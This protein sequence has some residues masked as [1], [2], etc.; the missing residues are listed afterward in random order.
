MLIRRET[1]ADRRAI[2]AVHNAAFATE[3]GSI[4]YEATLVDNLRAAGDVIAALSLVT[5]IDGQVVG[6]VLGSR[7][8]IDEH[9]SLGLGPLGVVPS[10]QKRG[11]GSALM[12]A[13]LA[14]ADALDSPEAVLLGDPGYYQRFGFQPAQPLGVIPPDQDWAQHF[15]IRT[16]TRWNDE[17][18]GTFR[19]APAFGID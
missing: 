3:D 16:L 2:H 18:K 4:S 1:P 9:L 15:Q 10:H 8:H 5:E 17:T 7:A 12:H 11:V 13:V 14:A 19:Y 6:H